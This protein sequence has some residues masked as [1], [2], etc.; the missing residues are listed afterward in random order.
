MLSDRRTVTSE[1]DGRLL[2]EAVLRDDTDQQTVH[3]D[4]H[5]EAGH[6]PV[7]ARTQLVDA[8]CD[9]PDVKAAARLNATLPAG[10][11]EI[12]DRLR[13]RCEN[14]QTRAA[15]ATTLAAGTV[16]TS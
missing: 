1:E 13:E 3:A 2:A 14:V 9:Q 12:L 6:L 8:V 7:G 5:V 15:G 4:F 11:S 10:D 16:P